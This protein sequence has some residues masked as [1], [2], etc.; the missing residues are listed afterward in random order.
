[1]KLIP[2]T[3]LPQLPARPRAGHKGLF[4]RVLIVGGNEAM[5]GAPVLAGAA[6]LRMG[7]GLVQVAMPARVLATGLSVV[8]EL[9]GLALDSRSR[10]PLLRAAEAADVIAIGPGLGM[11]DEARRW[12]TDLIRLDKPMVLDA[13]ALNFLARGRRWPKAFTARAV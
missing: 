10:Q 9:I 4:G 5:I 3:D 7:S 1:M 6:A 11:G 8:P 13:D 2:I 12:L